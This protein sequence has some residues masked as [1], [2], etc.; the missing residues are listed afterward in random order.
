[1]IRDCMEQALSLRIPLQVKLSAGPSW[2]SLSPLDLSDD[3]EANLVTSGECSPLLQQDLNDEEHEEGCE[4]PEEGH[5]MEVD[6]DDRDCVDNVSAEATDFTIL[7][8]M[9][10]ARNL[11]GQD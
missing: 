7:P 11:F 8:Q 10:V 6:G 5:G 2:G 4:D 1:M 9:E 3:V